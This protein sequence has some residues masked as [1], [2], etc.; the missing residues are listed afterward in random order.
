M[1]VD[2]TIP[3]REN[4]STSVKTF[5]FHTATA[6][7]FEQLSKCSTVRY[8]EQYHSVTVYF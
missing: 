3:H 4:L 2:I 7:E 1:L 6:L 8:Y 5:K